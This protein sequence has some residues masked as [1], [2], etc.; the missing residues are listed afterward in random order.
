MKNE[1]PLV[2]IVCDVY[3]HE[4]YLTDCLEGFLNQKTNFDF[5]ILI[6]DDASTDNSSKI[7]KEY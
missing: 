7:I 1:Q 5:E 2:S 3:N 6:N 4:P